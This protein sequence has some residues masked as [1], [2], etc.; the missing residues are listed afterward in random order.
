M[1][2][3]YHIFK[4]SLNAFLNYDNL[5]LVFYTGEDKFAKLSLK[6]EIKDEDLQMS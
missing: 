3:V 1:L 5:G 2:N 4:H 6:F